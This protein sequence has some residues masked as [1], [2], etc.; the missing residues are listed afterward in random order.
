M[1]VSLHFRTLR[2][3][4]SNW[5]MSLFFL[6]LPMQHWLSVAGT[7]DEVVE[8]PDSRFDGT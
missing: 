7:V 3:R 4:L 6:L 5:A 2:Q 8:A 1:S